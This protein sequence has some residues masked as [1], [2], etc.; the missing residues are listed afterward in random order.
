MPLIATK[1]NSS[2]DQMPFDFAEVIAAIAPRAVFVVAPLH[3]DNFDISGVHECLNAARP[4]FKLL[5]HPTTSKPS[6][7][8]VPTNSPTPNASRRTSS[9]V[10]F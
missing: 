4:I 6:T 5:G 10:G 8:T 1:Y 2:P 7:P 3:D 9:S